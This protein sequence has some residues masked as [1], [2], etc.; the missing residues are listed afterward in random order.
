MAAARMRGELLTGAQEIG[1]G[2]VKRLC[3]GLLAHVDSG[4]TTLSEA[5][6]Y[7]AGALRKL[8]RVDHRDAFLDT[9]AL[10]RAR[11]ITI[12]S[13][14][15][16]LRLPDAEF[17]L[18]DTPG[19][20]DF[21]SE[22]ERAL[23]VMDYAVLVVSGTDGIQSHTETLWRLL[24]R[25]GVPV[26]IF[27]NKMDLAGADR[28][29]RMAE[30]RRRFGS[31]CIDLSDPNSLDDLALCSEEL[32]ETV[33][34][35]GKPTDAQI[36]SAVSR[37]ELFPCCFGSALKA[38]GADALLDALRRWTLP[39]Q[40]A[41]EFGARV[42]KVTRDENGASLAWL[43]VTG[44]ELAVKAPLSSRADARRSWSGKADQLRL[45]S[46]AKYVL[47]NRA[48]PGMA[49]AVTGIAGA[50]AGEGLGAEP[51]A[52][53]PSL[54]PV[55]RY[56]VTLPAGADAHTALAQL[57]ELGEEDPQLHIAW[58]EGVGAIF[59]QL[60]GEVQL[61][62]LSSLAERRFGLK[63]GFDD[64]G[65]LY[66]E[67]IGVTVEGVGHYEPLR[68]YAEVHLVL[69]PGEPG[70]GVQLSSSCPTDE[71][72]L[73]W[74]RLILTHLAEKTHV[75][76]L[77]GSPLTDVKISLAAGR[78]HPKHTEGGDFRQATY[79]AVRQGLM[80][81]AAKGGC[82]LL[83]PWYDFTLRVPAENLGR[84]LADMPRLS[85]EFAPPETGAD[86]CV[87][88]GRAPVS[89]MRS[90]ARELAAYTRGRGQLSCLPGGYERCH[91]A[92]EVIAGI[93]YDAGADTA[94][95]ADSVFCSH[96]AGVLV[97]WD[98]V[99]GRM[100]LPGVLSRAER[101]SRE[102]EAETAVRAAR[103]AEYR[104]TL[105]AD[106]ELMAIFERTYGPIKRDGSQA[107]RTPRRPPAPAPANQKARPKPADSGPEHLLVDG[108]NVIFAWDELNALA[109]KS[110]ESARRRLMDI[111]CNYAG[112]THCVPIL[113][114]DAYKVKGGE[115]EV[116]RY[117]N[118]YV[119]YTKEAET[120]DMY[121]EK[122]THEIA[123]RFRTRV[124]TSDTTEQLIILGQGATRVSSQH[125]E[126]EVRAVEKE[127]REFVL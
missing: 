111:L 79:R 36:A 88:T 55:L 126:E 8:G 30:L 100:H 13:K 98:E 48:L 2:R 60:M 80:T 120:A 3:V 127:I 64:G 85:A 117:H 59:V 125:F 83:E 97:R 109:A 15:A 84:A 118:L 50:Y 95:S 99:P 71:L 56:R 47:V 77:T 101:L 78:A 103:A 57:R 37:R 33:A 122:A 42:F 123:R 11:G 112:Y 25:Y 52:A 74:Q 16:L 104:G 31:G 96:G 12:F 93:G 116:E 86:G 119:V 17:T 32:L 43:K 26:F 94:N 76:P 5:L 66:K 53:A 7:R 124:V 44:G 105:A 90:Y 58:D 41:G 65:I 28:F 49:V 20:V 69:S 63:L 113:V 82:V 35:G 102:S 39:A 62:V 29:A 110:M 75:G 115:R 91:N 34:G 6:L 67:T 24:G 54:S 121:I 10:E 51:D 38:E 9:D 45:Y 70:S 114:F 27:V 92:A 108:Y 19:H 61:E 72:A 68:H 22:A 89:L 14:Q 1:P 18:L 23:Q 87:I 107:M 40:D 46:G 106:K 21:S 81:A 4:K 73:N